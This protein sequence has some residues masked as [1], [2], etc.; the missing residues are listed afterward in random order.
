[1]KTEK[2]PERPSPLMKMQ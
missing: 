1:M 2:R